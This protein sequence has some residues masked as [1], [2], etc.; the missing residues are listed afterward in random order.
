M[1][2]TPSP[3]GAA[4]LTISTDIIADVLDVFSSNDFQCR[5][6]VAAVAFALNVR[7]EDVATTNHAERLAYA[8]QIMQSPMAYTMQSILYAV[9]A[10]GVTNASSS[11]QDIA[12]RIAVVFDMLAGV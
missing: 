7:D 3:S 11:D 12:D 10:D 4:G 5:V 6:A 2:I 9:V 1:P 8:R